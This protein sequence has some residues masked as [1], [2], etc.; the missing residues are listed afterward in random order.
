MHLIT[1]DGYVVLN[2]TIV[3][4]VW[5]SRNQIFGHEQ[6]TGWVYRCNKHDPGCV[7]PEHMVLPR[8]GAWAV[9]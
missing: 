8:T 5:V 4:V 9:H 7:T 3:E 2:C 1:T 6:Y